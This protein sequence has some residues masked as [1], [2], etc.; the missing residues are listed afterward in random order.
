[1]PWVA[2]HAGLTLPTPHLHQVPLT[3]LSPTVGLL[4]VFRINHSYARFQ[5]GRLL[6]GAAVRHCRDLARVAT[7]WLPP[8]EDRQQLLAHLVAY[9]WLLKAHLRAGRTRASPNDPT[10]YRDDPAENVRASGMP[11]DQASLLLASANR[12]YVCLLR[13]TRLLARQ[14][15]QAP[16]WVLRRCEEVVDRMGE[17]TGGCERIL[18]TPLPLSYTRFTGRSLVCWLLALPLAL[19]P[20]MGWSAVPAQALMAYLVLGIDE[21]GVEIEEP[22]AILPLQALC[23]AVR[24]DVSIAE[25]KGGIE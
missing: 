11:A 22:F 2:T 10:A 5:E 9:A 15:A 12:P 17:V 18:S 21:I 7:H 6:W 1:M 14:R 20:L 19:V 25:E 13:I 24:R 3:L 8:S 4:L 23:E 16:A